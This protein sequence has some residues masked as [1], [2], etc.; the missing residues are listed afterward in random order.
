MF[1]Q[2][3]SSCSLEQVLKTATAQGDSD[4][5]P[6]YCCDNSHV[7]VLQYMYICYLL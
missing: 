6:V 4:L 2:E 3:S 7:N 5:S 1:S